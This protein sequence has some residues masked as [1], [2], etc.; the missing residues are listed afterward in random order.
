MSAEFEVYYIRV[1]VEQTLEA[2]PGRMIIIDDSMS[3]VRLKQH[4]PAH[5][6]I[7][8]ICNNDNNIHQH[9]GHGIY[10]D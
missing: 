2:R 10:P 4:S 5:Y 8:L 9:A 6:Y 7:A 3:S 1:V